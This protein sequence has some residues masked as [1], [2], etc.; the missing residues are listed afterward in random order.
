MHARRTIHAVLLV[1]SVIA[2]FGLPARQRDVRLEVTGSGEYIRRAAPS[3]F[4]GLRARLGDRR[5]PTT[6][7]GQDHPLDQLVVSAPSLGFRWD[8]DSLPEMKNAAFPADL[9]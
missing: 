4:S 1:A 2:A 9:A 6:W 8:F 3:P 7:S 5:L